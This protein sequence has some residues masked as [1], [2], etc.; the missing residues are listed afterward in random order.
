M[1]MF[2]AMFLLSCVDAV[3]QH[4]QLQKDQEESGKLRAQLSEAVRTSCTS[5][6]SGRLL[7]PMPSQKK[8]E[9]KLMS[10][11]REFSG[12]KLGSKVNLDILMGTSP[13][14]ASSTK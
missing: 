11:M 4:T 2:L 1:V 9:P 10:P 13:K 5:P 3:A 12:D 7:L 8:K 14:K 6:R